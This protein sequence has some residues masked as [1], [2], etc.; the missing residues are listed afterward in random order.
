[1]KTLRQDRRPATVPMGLLRIALSLVVAFLAVTLLAYHLPT[2]HSPIPDPLS[3]IAN[4]QSSLPFLGINTALE[5]YNPTQRQA[6]LARLR[7]TG[8]GWVRQRLDWATLEPTPGNYAWATSDALVQDILAADLVPVIV[9]DGSPAWARAPQDRPPTDNPFAP[10]AAFQD[11]AR[12][13]AAV[14]S[15]YR[16]QLTF[17]QIWDEPN[18]APHWG[19]RLI[20]PV[21]YAQL[22][23]VTATAI[24]NADPDATILSAAL[25][26]TRDRGHTAIDEIAYL[27]RLYAAGAAPYFDVLAIQP[28]GFGTAPTDPRIGVDHLNFGRAHLIRQTMVA[29]GDGA[30]PIWAVRYGWNRQLAS[31]WATVPERDQIHFAV[32][33]LTLARREWPWLTA[34][35]WVIDQPKAPPTDPSWGFALSAPL[36]DAFRAW[37][38]QEEPAKAPSTAMAGVVS[39]DG[40]NG[41]LYG[42]L[43]LLALWRMVAIGR[44]LPWGTWGERYRALPWWVRALLWLALIALYYVAVWPPL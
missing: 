38:A 16:D 37:V 15:R 6:A 39:G 12:V 4:P 2:P 32:E 29:S 41:A 3:P 18:I 33:A 40:R 26:P 24:R 8:F 30:T 44:R 27:Q 31:P 7:A 14:A 5:Q 22:L 19:N 35:A 10:P 25:A 20:E 36:T 13:A 21:A 28:F 42:L 17:Y 1:M 11:F 43:L 9:L 34:M 23:R